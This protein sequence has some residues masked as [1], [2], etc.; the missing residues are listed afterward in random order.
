M[1]IFFMLDK[2]RKKEYFMKYKLSI[3]MMVKDE[4]LHLERC[5]N[6]I[7]KVVERNDVELIIVDT[8]SD[9]MTVDIAKRYTNK[10]YYKEW[11][12]DFSSMRNITIS[13]AT[14]EWILIIDADEN[15][16]NIEC[17]ETF[18]NREIRDELN[19]FFVKAKNYSN[20]KDM[21]SYSLIST[22]RIFRNDGNFRYDGKIH[23]QPIFKKPVEY[24]DLIIG[25]YGYI[26]MNKE[27]M[28]KKFYRTTK[29]LREELLKDPHNIY[30]LYQLATSYSM[31]GDITK[32]YEVSK[33]TYNLLLNHSKEDQL[34]GFA[35]FGVHLSSCIHAEKFTE[36]LEASLKSIK[37]RNDYIDGYFYALYAYEKL[38]NIEMAKNYAEKYIYISSKFDSLPISK[39]DGIAIYRNDKTTKK[40]VRELLVYYYE[41]NEKYLEA[42]KYIDKNDINRINIMHYINIYL[43]LEK[44]DDLLELF[45]YINDKE[46]K[47]KFLD[48]L[49]KKISL[50]D[51]KTQNDIR[52]RFMHLD[53]N[54]SIYCKFKSIPDSEIDLKL[55]VANNFY[56]LMDDEITNLYNG[57]ILSFI[58]ENS[59]LNLNYFTKFNR[60]NIFFYIS[61]FSKEK[62]NNVYLKIINWLKELNHNQLIIKNQFALKNILEALTINLINEYR[63]TG[64]EKTLHDNLIIFIKYIEVGMICIEKIYGLDGLSTKY[65][66][67]NDSETRF[68]IL[69]YLYKE[70]IE[71]GNI[72]VAL[73]YYKLAAKVYPEMS[74]FLKK[75]III[76]EIQKKLDSD[77]F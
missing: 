65:K 39:N 68:L 44:Y 18:L 31:H 49:E 57:D 25:H 59:V 48:I 12:D 56:K 47:N 17:L 3:C 73:N 20:I 8:G 51:E 13:Y 76:Q 28:D 22:P 45:N 41:K 30:Y 64:L 77:N 24:L 52:K 34:N 55:Q 7:K 38:G 54:Y 21:E 2:I 62:Y 58:I 60:A 27:I 75:Y 69:M 74:D 37:L 66:Y 10:L 35:V 11:F 14:G 61:Y 42:F 32:A 43:K 46:L 63:N 15:V 16:E 19:T 29:I 33:K 53:N 1:P 9:D 70:N 72:K 50:F 23:N 71:R 26:T 6:S 5:L 4:E 36:L 67:I 40:I